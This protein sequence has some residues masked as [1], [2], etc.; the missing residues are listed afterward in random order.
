MRSARFSRV[1]VTAS[2]M[3]SRKLGFCLFVQAAK[4]GLNHRESAGRE[5][6]NNYSGAVGMKAARLRRRKA[7][8]C[9]L[10]HHNAVQ[11]MEAF[12]ADRTRER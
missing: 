8:S 7:E 9:G 12:A 5:I 10:G 1:R 3:R 11:A 2:F 6:Q 4:K